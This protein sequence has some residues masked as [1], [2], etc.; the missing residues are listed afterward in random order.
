MISPG[1]DIYLSGITRNQNYYLTF[2]YKFGDRP[3]ALED[4][5]INNKDR[6]NLN[7][8]ITID[9]NSKRVLNCYYG[10]KGL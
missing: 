6:K 10:F 1:V 3:I 2:D 4:Y 8:A 9:V 7:H 5:K